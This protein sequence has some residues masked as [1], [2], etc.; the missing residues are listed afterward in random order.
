ML[1]GQSPGL[2]LP[3]DHVMEGTLLRPPELGERVLLLRLVRNGGCTAGA[4]QSGPVVSVDADE[5]TTLG[6]VYRI[7]LLKELPHGA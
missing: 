3:A 5:C 2:S 7:E 6:S 1:G 4:F